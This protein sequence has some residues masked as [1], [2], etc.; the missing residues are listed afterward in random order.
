MTTRID[1]PNNERGIIR[2]FALSMTETEAKALKDDAKT[3][4]H[5][6]GTDAV[7]DMDHVEVFPV[8]DLE[9]V[10]L[11]G[12]LTEGGAVPPDQLSADRAKLDRIG[13]WVLLVYS[14]AFHDQEATLTPVPA[15]TLIG[16]YGETRTDWRPAEKVEAESAKP[17]SAPAETVTKKPSDAAMSGRIAMIVLLVLGLLTWAMIWIGG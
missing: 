6:L 13:G 4:A 3:V 1:I 10:G 12:Y 5:V 16:T 17:Y 8:T 2:L 14:L 7:L 11:M 9:G 15:L